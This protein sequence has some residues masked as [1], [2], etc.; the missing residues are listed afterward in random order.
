M[1]VHINKDIG[2][3]IKLQRRKKHLSQ[4]SLASAAEVSTN[5]ISAIENAKG[6]ASLEVIHKVLL[7][8][9]I[10]LYNL[11]PLSQLSTMR[12]DMLKEAKIAYLHWKELNSIIAGDLNSRLVNL[13]E[14][15]SEN[16]VCSSLGFTRN[17][18]ISGDATDQDGNIVEIKAT[19]N[20]E[21]DLTSFSPNQKFDRLI[22]LRLNITENRALI[23]DIQL[24]SEELGSLP[25]NYNETV[26]DQQRQNRRP[27]LSLIKYIKEKGLKP[28]YELVLN[29]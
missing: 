7:S 2:N 15:I 11:L 14:A 3:F 29:T 26:A 13:P 27:R 21:R 10:N 6:R 18:N 17:T 5:K 24:N 22:F 28:I 4:E 8:L 23:Y 9:G 20:F 16:L 25:V 12:K 19:S 1:D